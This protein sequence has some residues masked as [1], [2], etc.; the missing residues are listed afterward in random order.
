MLIG[1][2]GFIHDLHEFTAVHRRI[3]F[4]LRHLYRKQMKKGRSNKTNTSV[5][6]TLRKCLLWLKN[7]RVPSKSFPGLDSALAH[8]MCMHLGSVTSIQKQAGLASF[9]VSGAC[10]GGERIL[11]ARRQAFQEKPIKRLDGFTR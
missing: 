8:I 3:E 11:N 7:T 10:R 2:D 5:F 6:F 1:T 4:C 9:G